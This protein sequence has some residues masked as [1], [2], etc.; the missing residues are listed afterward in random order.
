VAPQPKLDSSAQTRKTG[1]KY[2]DDGAPV[3]LDAFLSDPQRNRLISAFQLRSVVAESNYQHAAGNVRV[4]KL[5]AKDDKDLPW[6]ASLL[7]D[8]ALGL[9]VGRLLS[10]LS[11][12]R[13]GQ[14]KRIAA[15]LDEAAVSQ[16]PDPALT[17]SRRMQQSFAGVSDNSIKTTVTAVTSMGKSQALASLAS[18]RGQQGASKKQESVDYLG[19]LRDAASLA[20][21]AFRESIPALA[22]DAD[23]LVLY[24][25]M[26][27]RHHLISIYEQAISEKLQRYE[28]A[29]VA[30]IGRR[31]T[32]RWEFG[33]GGAIGDSNV[34]VVRDVWVQWQTYVSGYPA[35]LVFRYEDGEWNIRDWRG[36]P[37]AERKH[38]RPIA[39]PA[40]GTSNEPKS[41]Y[42]VPKEFVEVAQ[43]RHRQMWGAAPET[44]LIDDEAYAGWDPVRADKARRN[45]QGR[46]SLPRPV[47]SSARPPQPIRV[48]DVFRVDVATGRKA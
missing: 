11:K 40:S 39:E 21:Q 31:T 46:S 18:Q 27:E 35:E 20:H 26:N 29:E 5:L 48:P 23:L 16:V 1:D 9:V 47:N 36:E 19:Q 6:I 44:V 33:E 15:L 38:R 45:K 3:R 32:E 7:I 25:S 4:D 30:T 17:I 13:D 34:P 41:M 42:I 14:G 8:V 12:L 2:I 22:N 37:A 24:D 43:L 28:D 10:S